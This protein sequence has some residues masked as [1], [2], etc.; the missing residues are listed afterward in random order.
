MKRDINYKN[1]KDHKIDVR[2][3][4][5][6]QLLIKALETKISKIV[7]KREL[8]IYRT[9]K[10]KYLN[11]QIL[12]KINNWANS[13]A[14]RSA[15]ARLAVLAFY[16]KKY[17]SVDKVTFELNI[18]KPAAKTMIDYCLKEGWLVSDDFGCIQASPFSEK[19]F[20]SYV[21]KLSEKTHNELEEFYSLNLTIRSIQETLN[22]E[23]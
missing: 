21:R 16:E 2:N 8:E 6:L 7:A 19:A 12:T 17:I 11:D 14:V 20:S 18:S 4:K 22:S 15:F 5:G 1:K 9:T 23:N 13:S 3:K 10:K